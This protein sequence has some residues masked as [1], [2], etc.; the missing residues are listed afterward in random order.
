MKMRLVIT[1]TTDGAE[2]ARQV[3][4]RMEA[5]VGAV[6]K[7][8][9][10]LVPKRSWD[11]H[12]TIKPSV[13]VA[14]PVVKGRVT[15]GGGKVNYAL[16]VERGTSRMAAQPYLRPALLQTKASDLT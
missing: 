8:A 3:A 5:L 1:K 10:R 16:F 13:T 2:I 4:P 14:G 15:A 9:R 11:L 7:R 6:A 12:N